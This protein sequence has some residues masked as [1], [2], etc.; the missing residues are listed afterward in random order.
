MSAKTAKR[1]IAAMTATTEMHGAIME[2][3]RAAAEFSDNPDMTEL[4]A[5]Q[6]ESALLVAQEALSNRELGQLQNK[7]IVWKSIT[8]YIGFDIKEQ[9]T[10]LDYAESYLIRQISSIGSYVVSPTA[11]PVTACELLI[12]T[13]K[14]LGDF[15][16][17]G[18]AATR[19]SMGL[20]F[21]SIRALYDLS[22]ATVAMDATPYRLQ[23]HPAD[24]DILILAAVYRF[25]DF[26]A[27]ISMEKR[28]VSVVLAALQAWGPTLP[29][30]LI[31]TRIL[32][33]VDRL[34]FDCK[35]DG[36][37]V[38]LIVNVIEHHLG[39]SAVGPK[40]ACA[41]VGS[42]LA[43]YGLS[44]PVVNVAKQLLKVKIK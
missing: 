25:N 29:R 40:E 14:L 30:A 23:I 33:V 37:V 20:D 42:R 28:A 39:L 10:A 24:K 16:K 6:T 27:I 19:P 4:I 2:C 26:L 5:R 15:G 13:V 36:S 3:T 17:L 12:Q 44:R 21:Y 22:R 1:D 41:I 35:V 43:G 18:A 38:F 8:N 31:A 11:D 9:E 7:E 32:A 34:L